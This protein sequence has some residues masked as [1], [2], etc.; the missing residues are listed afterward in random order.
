MPLEDDDVF[1]G[2]Q[3]L[4]RMTMTSEDDD[5]FGGFDVFSG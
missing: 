2:Q 4:W 1:G 3:Y 5:A